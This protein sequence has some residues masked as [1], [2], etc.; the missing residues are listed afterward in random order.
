M[1]LRNR[2]VL[3]TSNSASS[4]RSSRWAWWSVA[5]SCARWRFTS[6][7][8]RASSGRCMSSSTAR[9]K[10]SVP[11]CSSGRSGQSW[12]LSRSDSR[13]D[14]CSCTSSVRRTHS[15]VGVGARTTALYLYRTCR[16][17][18]KRVP[19]PLPWR[20]AWARRSRRS[21][22]CTQCK[23]LSCY[24]SDRHVC[25]MCILCFC[26][27]VCVFVVASVVVFQWI[28]VNYPCVFTYPMCPT[29]Q[30]MTWQ[31]PGGGDFLCQIDN[32]R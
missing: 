15:C 17:G 10:R 31:Y 9:R 8:S 30:L 27:S 28:D 25:L 5:R 23:R 13:A 3:I 19:C 4:G 6:S 12:S 22:R 20:R 1:F 11:A 18:T 26:V 29:Q 21:Q 24:R 16:C 32:D 14:L 7:R 2:D